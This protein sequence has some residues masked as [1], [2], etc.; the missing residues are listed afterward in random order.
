MHA[1]M[2]RLF[3]ICRSLSGP[4]N[5]ET[6]DILSENLP[7]TKI[8]V[9]SGS[10]VFDWTVPDEW[11][12]RE[13][14]IEDS[15]GNRVVD[16]ANH[17][18]HVVSYSTAV[19]DVMSYDE[20]LPHLHSLPEQPNAIP[21]VTFYYKRDWGFCLP[22]HELQALS[23]DGH[24]K[25]CIDST[26]EPGSITLGE[27]IIP[28][29]TAEEILLS[30]NICHPSMANNELSGPVMLSAIGQWLLSLESRW[31]TY[32]LLFLPETIGAI[33]YLA[34]NADEMKSKTVAGYQVVCVGGPD[35]FSLIQTRQGNTL[36]DRMAI[37]VL[38][39]SGQPYEVLDFTRRASDERQY[40]SPG[41][42]LPVAVLSKSLFLD[43]DA[44]HTSLDDLDYVTP[45]NM[46]ASLEMY[47]KIVSGLE[48]NRRY[49]VTIEG[50]EPQLG[51]RGLYPQAGG[52]RHYFDEIS[53]FVAY[54]DGENDVLDIAEKHGRAVGDY[55][56]AINQLLDAGLVEATN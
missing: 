35:H 46:A 44:Y 15:A 41:V 8:E 53:E 47:A 16:F 3:P 13:A 10:K 18:L 26:L 52:G 38:Q 20:L 28:G 21:Y 55:T 4:G 54:A 14:W 23:K 22:H 32:R 33:A 50:G 36:T 19:D 9:P 25:V 6:L 17:N 39:H 49:R 43:Y 45:E 31:Y 42:N 48:S 30:T 37:N 5:R 34:K 12:I 7:I 27:C 51:P 29:D 56:A 2:A 1:L 40:N 24:Y 11:T